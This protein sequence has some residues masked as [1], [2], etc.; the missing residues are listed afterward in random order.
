MGFVFYSVVSGEEISALTVRTDFDVNLHPIPSRPCDRLLRLRHLLELIP[1]TRSPLRERSSWNWKDN[2]RECNKSAMFSHYKHVQNNFI[3]KFEIFAG[4]F[5]L[6]FMWKYE[7]IYI[8]RK[9]ILVLGL[10]RTADSGIIIM[11]F[12][13]H[14]I[15]SL[16]RHVNKLYS[17]F[18]NVQYFKMY[19]VKQ[20]FKH[21]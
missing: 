8:Y 9:I 1:W 18:M 6:I 5:L 3:G 4:F 20:N 21:Y 10:V 16:K 7:V 19:F 11:R 17:I 12:S 13:G 2:K 15:L 14:T